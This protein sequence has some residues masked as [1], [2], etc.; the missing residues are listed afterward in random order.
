MNIDDLKLK[1]VPAV[2]HVELLCDGFSVN[3][4]PP[5]K[6]VF[7]D[8]LKLIESKRIWDNGIKR[9]IFLIETKTKANVRASSENVVK[10]FKEK[11]ISICKE[12]MIPELKKFCKLNPDV[13]IDDF[14]PLFNI[15]IVKK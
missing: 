11:F 8:V 9:L 12:E 3:V 14:R 1:L 2:K 4:A 7:N 13:D 5:Y 15:K 6:E 10:Q